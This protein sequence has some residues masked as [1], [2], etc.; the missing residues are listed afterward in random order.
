MES[1]AIK[2]GRMLNDPIKNLNTLNRAGI[3]FTETEKRKIT[4]L[5]KS[6]KLLEAQDI[7]LESVEGRV[8]GLAEESATPWERMTAALGQVGDSIG[9]ALLGP[10]D[11][12]NEKIQVWLASPQS[13]KDIADITGAFV[14]MGEAAKFVLDIV[15]TLKKGIDAIKQF[16]GI[17]KYSEIPG[18]KQR[19]SNPNP[20]P[21]LPN[22]GSEPFGGT[23]RD[24]ASAPIINFN[25][26]IDSVSAGREV[27]RVLADYNRANGVR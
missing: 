21:N 15:L 20:N 17:S 2:L 9:E 19:D 26:P 12:M 22:R 3:T 23:S 5:A 8:K 10:L 25:A 13:K 4:E 27:A 1:N 7:I 14:A 6:G 11:D 16:F 18:V 24:R